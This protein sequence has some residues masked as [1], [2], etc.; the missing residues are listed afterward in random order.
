MKRGLY[1]APGDSATARAAATASRFAEPT[2][3]LSKRCRGSTCITL[4]GRR[5]QSL[6]HE[7]GDA[8]QRLEDTGT[9]QRVGAELGHAAK[10]QRVVQ[11]RW[12]EN[13]LTRQIL[14]VVLNN[15][16]DDARVDALLGEI[17]VQVLETLDVL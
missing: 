12:R 13:Q 8:S 14:L 9:V 1:T 5:A 17:R 3:K 4:F 7:L 15:E 6:E 10:V 11:L 16:R 2:M